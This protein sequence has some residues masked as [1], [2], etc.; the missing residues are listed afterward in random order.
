M[1]Q[2][3]QRKVWLR[4]LLVFVAAASLAGLESLLR[5]RAAQN[6]AAIFAERDKWQRPEEVMDELGIKPGSVV[7]DVGC[8]SGYFTFHLAHRVGPAGKV[9]A[10]DVRA[11]VLKKIQMRM[12][13]EH[14]KQIQVV[15]GAPDNPY[16]PA[17]K[18]DAIL[19]VNA[20]HE[21]KDYD[22]MLRGMYAALRPGGVLGIIDH[23]A[24][25]GQPRSDYQSQH[26]IPEELVRQDL[27]RNGFHFLR[28]GAGFTSAQS[29]KVYF[30]L[31]YERPRAPAQ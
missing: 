9:Y 20:Y 3:A 22:A 29:E 10:E 26:R 23:E 14:L 13:Q 27:A 6:D 15:E 17:G 21:M 19:V 1:N 4:V 31:I 11:D 30:F 28:R 8:G 24:E 18:L 12:D 16:L 2:P 7:A 5:L 25:P